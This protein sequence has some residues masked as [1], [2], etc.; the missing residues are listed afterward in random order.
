MTSPSKLSIDFETASLLDLRRTGVHTYS[1]HPSTRVLCMSFAF[2]NQPVQ[3]WREGGP[4]PKAVLDHVASGGTVSGWNVGF[5]W[6]IW[7]NTLM[8]Q[9]GFD[10]MQVALYS[11]SVSQ[12]S[13]TMARA[14]YWGLPLLLDQ[15]GP[16]AGVQAHKDKEGHA[17]MMRMCK[18]RSFN[19]LTGDVTWWHETDPDKF[20]RLCAYC[21][22]DV[23]VERA[24]GD[25]IPDLPPD[26][27]ET[28]ALDQTVNARGVSV[29]YVLVERLRDLADQA[30]V[31]A[32][33][34][35][36]LLT[37]GQVRTI[38]STKPLL[39]WLRF[40]GYPYDNLRKGTVAERL[41]EPGL[42]DM[43]RQG[44]ELRA[45]GAKT[46]AAKLNAMLTACPTRQ[47]VGTV[48]GMLQYY[49]ASRTG[50]WAGRLIQLQNMPRGEIKNVDTAIELILGG[51]SYDMI[52][53]LFGPV[54]AVIS[55][56]LRGC[57]VANRALRRKLVVADF[58][59]I[60]A[61]MVAWLA[62]QIDVLDV[63]AS[64]KDIYVHTAA[65]IGSTNRQLG[66]VL[67]LAC[68]F[69][70][71][72]RKFLDTAKTYGV[73]LT[74][75]EAESAVTLWRR[76]NDKI[77]SFWWEC[78]RAAR[79][80]ILNPTTTVKVGHL[81]FGMYRGNMLIRLPSGRELVYRGAALVPSKDRPGQQDISYWGTNQYTRKW[82]RLRTY[83][84][85]LVENVTQATARDVMRDTM[86]AAN[87]AGMN[88]ILTVHDELL[89]DE[90][91][92]T[93]DA[94]LANL[95]GIMRTPPAWA[96]GLPVD[97]AGWVGDR[98]KK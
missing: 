1:L 17:L 74:E 31:K 77:V 75:A 88:V 78:D 8:R 54:L 63:F 47:D 2:G 73:I 86:R 30:A 18:P 93:A 11:L 43:E 79:V 62:G 76:S 64:G 20:D 66:K 10:P 42:S 98:Y 32:N 6:V 45:E 4:F 39:E 40:H 26:E 90:D 55:S 61:R 12:L 96:T 14:A 80:V 19:V 71:S 94:S 67:V 35:I 28:W 57:I 72:W 22:Q 25:A 82:E 33:E 87:N 53:A 38:N 27:R 15:A 84:G 50:R 13:C 59:Q 9:L 83:G 48:R 70:M 46:S 16:A 89:N 41:D 81:T 29:D 34:Q 37:N 91:E 92:A 44:L 5:E 60:E 7:N 23:E 69:G 65:K 85:K 95:L 58:S 3:R 52:E 49:G 56:C 24:V 68:G 36:N 21:D 97:G 51:A